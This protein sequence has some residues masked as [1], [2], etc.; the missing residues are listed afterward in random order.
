[1]NRSA[2]NLMIMKVIVWLSELV[3]T[4]VIKLLYKC[5]EQRLIKLEHSQSAAE[6]KCCLQFFRQ[7]AFHIYVIN[8]Y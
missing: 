2:T 6:K 5:L 4:T 1:M 3:Q 8:L 7:M